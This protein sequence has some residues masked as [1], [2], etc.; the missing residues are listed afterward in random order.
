[1]NLNTIIALKDVTEKH[2]D[3]FPSKPPVCV[4]AGHRSRA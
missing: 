3:H 2:R 4:P 1:M